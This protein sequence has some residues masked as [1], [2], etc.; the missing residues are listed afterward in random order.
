MKPLHVCLPLFVIL[1]A[2]SKS[3]DRSSDRL[4]VSGK[5]LDEAT[6][7][8]VPAVAVHIVAEAKRYGTFGYFGN[9]S[10]LLAD[11]TDGDG[12]YSLVLEHP[13]AN[14]YSV[15]PVAQGKYVR[16]SPIDGQDYTVPT[17]GNHTRNIRMFREARLIVQLV[18]TTPISEG[19]VVI[20][21]PFEVIR[22]LNQ[23]RDTAVSM[24]LIGKKAFNNRVTVERGVRATIAT[25]VFVAAGETSYLDVEF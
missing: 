11:T 25:T 15:Y 24:P 12:N 14:A 22:I 2:C 20:V 21:G 16:S 17:T 4:S 10:P 18:K 13:Q 7:K 1:G 19:P 9:E 6:G 8:P 5:I 23:E 3:D